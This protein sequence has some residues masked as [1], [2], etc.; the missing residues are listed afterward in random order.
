M[1]AV[2]SAQPITRTPPAANSA[3]GGGASYRVQRGDTLGEIARDH[4]V[5]LEALL[6]VNPQISNPD[7]I[8]VGQTVNL[9]SADHSYTVRSG[10]TLSAIAARNGV[11]VDQLARANQIDNPNMI[12]VGDVLRM[13][14]RSGAVPAPPDTPVSKPS[15]AKPATPATPTTPT[16]PG[17]SGSGRVK[18]GQLPN[19]AG[20]NDAQRYDL[21]SAQVKQFGN[22][23]VQADLAAGRKVVLSLRQDTD[24]R[25]NKGLGAYDDRMVML[26]QGADG[27]KHAVEFR[28]NTE[29]S[30]QYEDGGPYT[31]KPVGENYGGDSRGDQGRLA[32][33]TYAF[34]RGT[35]LNAD[36]LLAGNDQVTERDTNH[37]GKFDDG[38]V[39]AKGGY[40]M[41]IHIGGASNTY[42]A[43][44]LTLPPSE[45]ER[46]FAQLGG[47][48]T[49][50]NVVVNTNKL[51][52]DSTAP[53][54]G[55]TATKPVAGTTGSGSKS[56]T[57][58][59]WQRAADALGVDV[60]S[61]KAVA[62]V[63]AKKSGFLDDGRP[64]I[65]FEA[66]QFA[67]RTGD[68]YDSSHPN[69]SS[70]RWNRDLYVGGA[71]EYKR[72]EEAMGL[73]RDAALKSASWGRFQIMGFNHKAA[74]Y[75]NVE[76][77]V[78]A[79]KQNEGKQLD[80]FVN[81]IKSDA[82]MH[83]ALQKHDWAGFAYSYNGSG[84]AANNYDTRMAEAYARFAK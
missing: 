4:G 45:H 72:L 70:A 32:D 13:P 11:S 37:N 1:S 22:A 38:V 64:K 14:G 25:I 12:F 83:K 74:G 18:A 62:E 50:R 21:Y 60:A 82:T 59:D 67:A 24:T 66:H 2:Q 19:T 73:N 7:R 44:C 27:S 31:R 81:F 77:F 79:M 42:S 65:L 46:F 23:A 10:D 39:T 20:L 15:G 61:I 75:N 3:D 16:E 9:P 63:E 84:Y 17:S 36:A 33:G 35:F 55:A 28:A 43:G 5:S 29:P 71:G 34:S 40:G 30:G 58:A 69:I 26:W 48:N 57:A 80:A 6:A 78:N 53:A 41:H 8:R 47:Q 76:D 68:R 49:V 52:A 54:A 51:T 56:L